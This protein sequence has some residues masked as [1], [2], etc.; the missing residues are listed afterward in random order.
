ME[1]WLIQNQMWFRI[2]IFLGLF[3]LLAAWETF[4]AWRPWLIS[5]K[6][7]WVRHLSLTFLS[8]IL[9]RVL[10]PVFLITVALHVEQKGLGILSHS[11]LPYAVQVIVGF[12]CLD[13]V[14][15]IQHRLF[16]KYQWLW[17]IH[18]VH[19]MDRQ[20]DVSTGVR[21]HPLEE[22]ISMG[23]KMLGVAFF[24]VSALAVFLF[25]VTLNAMT[26][27]AHVN[28]HLP[29]P[30]E[31]IL[32]KMIITPGM[33]RIHHSDYSPE[34]NSN[35]GF[36]FSWWDKMFDSYTLVPAAGERKFA[37]GLEEYQD[38]KYQTF[39]NMLLVPFNIKHLKVRYKKPLKTKFKL[40][41]E[42]NVPKK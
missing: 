17:R 30:V 31:K 3:A 37:M 12:I 6:I 28:V 34:T 13:L 15:Y 11:H 36:I 39:I 21:F 25:E 16:H 35:Y 1:Q 42:V 7:R 19:H 20:I 2:L 29:R 23:V 10:F 24:G 4:Y 38:P 32:R 27:F 18:R 5:R 8:K 33:H 26:M 14:M 41:E 22:I 40:Y 9:L